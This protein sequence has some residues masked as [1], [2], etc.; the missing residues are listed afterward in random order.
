MEVFAVIVSLLL[1]IFLAY[2]GFSV[3]L[4]APICALLA[5]ALSGNATLLGTYT[6]IFMRGLGNFIIK[7]FPIF[8]LGAIFGKVMDHSGAARSIAHWIVGKLGSGQAILAIV[9][10]CAILTYG[11]VSIFIVAFGVFPMAKELFKAAEIPKRLIPGSIGLGSFTFSMTALPGTIQIH[12]VIPMPYFRTDAF[13]AP[14]FGLV[15]SGL[16]FGLG[17]VY[18]QFR[19]GKARSMKEGYGFDEVLEEVNKEGQPPI[20]LAFMP[21]LL[22]IVGNFVFSNVWIPTWNVDY[23]QSATFGHT[24]LDNV[25]GIWG[26][27]LAM[28]LAIGFSLL[29]FRKSMG[30]PKSTI[31]EGISGTMLPLFNTASEV[32]YG[33]T[34]ATLTG[35][36]LIK[37][38]VLGLF[39]E[40]PLL[41]LAVAV[42]MLAGITGSASGG[43]AIALETLGAEFYE[44]ALV[45]D[46]DPELMHRIATMAS[47]GLDSL[48]H[49]GAVITL[50]MICGLTHRQS[51]KEIGV[52]TL[53]IPLSIMF[54]MVLAVSAFY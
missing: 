52:T 37:N 2:R 54:A 46:I 15:A 5:V 13:A 7:Y 22:L 42:N 35:F 4:V 9:L 40:N 8:L 39:S 21:V 33:S 11:G 1:L 44:L 23:L 50:L 47:S 16:I 48:P 6:E 20:A 43:L 3:I 28:S 45:K 12:N 51:Y 17:L 36:E 26:I 34:I 53:L 31:N 30:E 32:G 14:I 19:A 27:I 41:S 38:F 25:R 18:L 10:S 49:N 29:A 24:D